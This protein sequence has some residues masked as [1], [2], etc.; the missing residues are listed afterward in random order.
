VLIRHLTEVGDR[1]DDFAPCVL[2]RDGS[3]PREALTAVGAAAEA[4]QR[5]L[6]LLARERAAARQFLRTH[7]RSVGVEQLEAA[8][9][10]VRT[11]GHELL[12]R[13]EARQA[14]R[15]VVRVQA[16]AGCGMYDDP[17]AEMRQDR[18]EQLARPRESRRR[19]VDG[20]TQRLP[21]TTSSQNVSRV[22][23]AAGTG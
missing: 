3:D 21:P 5:R 10:L 11:R 6:G 16:L 22:L 2:D 12:G 14:R 17:V 13:R 23:P 4:H 1:V 18:S 20:L 19:A 15:F 8:E 9:R 7:H